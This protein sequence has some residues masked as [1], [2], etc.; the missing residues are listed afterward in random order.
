M[1][2]SECVARKDSGKL[3]FISDPFENPTETLWE[4]VEN[5][6]ISLLKKV[7][8][9][10]N[11]NF[12]D[13]RENIGTPTHF[14]CM[15]GYLNI[16][17]ML[18]EKGV[19]IS[20]ETVAS[21]N[22]PFLAAKNGHANVVEYLL[23][24]DMSFT[25]P[26]EY[27]GKRISAFDIALAEK[28]TSTVEKIL[29]GIPDVTPYIIVCLFNLGNIEL[30]TSIEDRM[31]LDVE[32]PLPI[33]LSFNGKKG[34]FNPVTAAAIGGSVEALEYLIEHE[35]DVN[36]PSSENQTAF[37]L[38]MINGHVEFVEKLLEIESLEFP[39][40]DLCSS[41]LLMLASQNFPLEICKKLVSNDW[42]FLDNGDYS[43][44]ASIFENE[45][46]DVDRVDFLFTNNF[47][48]NTI[49]R[50]KDNA[51]ILHVAMKKEETDLLDLILKV[52]GLDVNIPFSDGKTPLMVAVEKEASELSQL[53]LD[54]HA[55]VS[56]DIISITND[57]DFKQ[58]LQYEYEKQQEANNNN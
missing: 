17:E 48:I 20:D 58:L 13:Q 9:L 5:N 25:V 47:P 3:F 18:L 44:F 15:N 50:K 24:N 14:A 56:L 2:L 23:K 32:G 6:D 1:E 30:I 53:L 54:K 16:F 51:R 46:L 22:F 4:A 39:S 57:E 45:E 37:E 31:N 36:K 43:N 11:V 34:N 52:D 40:Q 42:K 41:E 7:L 8:R 33:A 26:L 29:K 10:K 55:A 35:V 12:F 38:A 49:I 19:G 21:G 27:E 28:H